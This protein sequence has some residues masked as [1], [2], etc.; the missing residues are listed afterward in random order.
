MK[1]KEHFLKHQ[2]RAKK[3][4]AAEARAAGKSAEREDGVL[5]N[6]DALND[7]FTNSVMVAKANEYREEV[8]LPMF[9]I[10]KE[11][12]EAITHGCENN[13]DINYGHPAHK[14]GL[15]QPL[16]YYAHEPAYKSGSTGNGSQ[17]EDI[18][19]QRFDSDT[20]YYKAVGLSNISPVLQREKLSPLL[21]KGLRKFRCPRAPETVLEAILYDMTG[22]SLG[23]Q[24]HAMAVTEPYDENVLCSGALNVTGFL[25]NHYRMAIESGYQL[26]LTKHGLH[27]VGAM[28]EHL[29]SGGGGL[30]EAVNC[31]LE[32]F[33]QRV[34]NDLVADDSNDYS[35]TSQLARRPF[36]LAWKVGRLE[37]CP[38]KFQEAKKVVAW[39][40]SDRREYSNGF[41]EQVPV[42]GPKTIDECY[43][44]RKFTPAQCKDAVTNTEVNVIVPVEKNGGFQVLDVNQVAFD[45]IRSKKRKRGKMA[46]TDDIDCED[47]MPAMCQWLLERDTSA[48]LDMPEGGSPKW[49]IYMDSYKKCW[50]RWGF[51]LMKLK[52]PKK[53]VCLLALVSPWCRLMFNKKGTPMGFEQ[54]EFALRAA[55]SSSFVEMLEGVLCTDRTTVDR[56]LTKPISKSPLFVCSFITIHCTQFQHCIPRHINLIVKGLLSKE[57]FFGPEHHGMAR[58]EGGE[59]HELVIGKHSRRRSLLGDQER[60]DSIEDSDE[61]SD[62]EDSALDGGDDDDET[63]AK[64]KAKKKVEKHLKRKIVSLAQV[65][66]GETVE[67]AAARVYNHIASLDGSSNKNKRF[68][69]V[70]DSGIFIHD[71]PTHLSIEQHYESKLPNR[72][73]RK[74]RTSSSPED[75]KLKNALI[76]PYKENGRWFYV[77]AGG[78]ANPGGPFTKDVNHG[79]GSFDPYKCDGE[80][81][82][83]DEYQYKKG[84]NGSGKTRTFVKRHQDKTFR[85]SE[86][87]PITFEGL[88]T[89][90]TSRN[91]PGNTDRTK[92]TKIVNY[93]IVVDRTVSNAVAGKTPNAVEDPNNLYVVRVRLEEKPA[94]PEGDKKRKAKKQGGG[95]KKKTK[96]TKMFK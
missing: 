33:A 80:V 56:S 94:K 64:K 66:E 36:S 15:K 39:G 38:R 24:L 35:N 8:A 43:D 78:T 40:I 42:V 85:V 41:G 44:Y 72:G 61:D 13:Q 63:K 21:L 95:E 14:I 83:Y 53:K 92:A 28:F 29:M 34:H 5:L 27:H 62:G 7:R 31:G 77:T 81:I 32:D 69:L 70:M 2:E 58:K 10:L 60:D 89:R 4:K 90:T 88:R 86:F 68:R 84:S 79:G 74:N 18:L 96:K 47:K 76:Q 23:F 71:S 82:I 16:V 54:M 1:S 59:G 22:P 12:G 57:N 45:R 65:S 46:G 87:V 25:Y 67:D 11:N 50:K 55:S 37:T 3:K 51:I 17:K 19:T 73:N 9:K 52:H 48:S 26:D 49:E 30:Y 20:Q 6:F 75:I 91:G 93:R